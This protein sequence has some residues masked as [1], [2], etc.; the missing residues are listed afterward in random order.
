METDPLMASKLFY[1]HDPCWGN[2]Q[3]T[4]RRHVW[5][6]SKLDIYWASLLGTFSIN[7]I[8]SLTVCATSLYQTRRVYAVVFDLTNSI[9]LLNVRQL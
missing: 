1:A 3:A 9:Y 5:F 4:G 6:L 2:R 7:V 8:I